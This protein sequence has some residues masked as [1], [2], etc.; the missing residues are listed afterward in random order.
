MT[1]LVSKR[2]EERRFMAFSDS[3]HRIQAER[4]ITGLPIHF[5]W[6]LLYI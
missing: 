1:G 2:A 6:Y 5:P 3:D 4:L